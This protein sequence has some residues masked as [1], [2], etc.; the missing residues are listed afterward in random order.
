MTKEE[1][2]VL[3]DIL[4]TLGDL[5]SQ[6]HDNYS[7]EYG[8]IAEATLKRL[9]AEAEARTPL[10]KLLGE[11]LDEIKAAEYVRGYNCGRDEGY[12]NGYQEG[13]EYGYAHGHGVGYDAGVVDERSREK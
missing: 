1:I 2:A 10:E 11:Q 4:C 12:N 13:R 6:L 5:T 8:W 9:I 3:K 7:Q